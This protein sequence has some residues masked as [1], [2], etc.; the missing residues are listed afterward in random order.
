MNRE[1][2]FEFTIEHPHGHRRALLPDGRR[3]AV[4][5]IDGQTSI[6]QGFGLPSLRAAI[7]LSFLP[8]FLARLGGVV[9]IVP[10]Y[11]GANNGLSAP[12]CTASSTTRQP[13][14]K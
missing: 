4:A 9:K 8:R 3:S 12:H 7:R 13:I 11:T 6:T 2:R 14:V 1:F 5:Q 10:W